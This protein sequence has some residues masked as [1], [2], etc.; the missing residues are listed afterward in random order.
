VV[1]VPTNNLD[2]RFVEAV[3]SHRD[4]LR[5]AELNLKIHSI[6]DEDYLLSIERGEAILTLEDMECL[7]VEFDM[8]LSDFCIQYGIGQECL[9]GSAG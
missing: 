8:N 3:R 1:R 7:M 9:L 2:L 6:L 4:E 5:H